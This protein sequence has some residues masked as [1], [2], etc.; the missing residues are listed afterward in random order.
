MSSTKPTNHEIQER[1][2][3]EKILKSE[4]GLNSTQAER[5]IHLME[6]Y[7]WSPSFPYVGNKIGLNDW[8]GK[9][10]LPA[11]FDEIVLN[12]LHEDF[13]F[14][15]HICVKLNNKYGIIR[16]EKEGYVWIK[17]GIYDEVRIPNKLEGII[18]TRQD[19]IWQISDL[20]TNEEVISGAFSE[21]SNYNGELFLNG[22]AFFRIGDLYGVVD[23]HGLSTELKF[24]EI[25]THSTEGLVEVRLGDQWGYI[26]NA[27][28][29][30]LS[31]DDA[32][33]CYNP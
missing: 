10:I 7:D 16:L 12:Q 4:A 20:S 2:H 28:N 8:S 14:K 23:E 24:N 25:N 33:F 21:V 26:D 27:G 31:A 18:A 9:Q 32:F 19:K 29:F 22:I 17:D 1:I 3:L 15:Q 6:E 5:Y 30:T 11:E 13:Y